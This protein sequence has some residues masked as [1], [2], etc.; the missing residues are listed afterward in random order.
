[1]GDPERDPLNPLKGL[2]EKYS[3]VKLG[4]GIVGKTGAVTL[5]LFA[6]WAIVLWRLSGTLWL[7]LALLGSGITITCVYFWW[8]RKAHAFAERHPGIALLEGAHLIEYQKWEAQIKG[9]PPLKSPI[10]PNPQL[11]EDARSEKN[12]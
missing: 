2:A 4:R 7:D 8:A 12:Q 5:G 9:H 10:V 3:Q 1:M 6:L 11:I